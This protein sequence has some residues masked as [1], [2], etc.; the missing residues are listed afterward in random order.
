MANFISDIP[1]SPTPNGSRQL[2]FLVEDDDNPFL[3]GFVEHSQ[4][5]MRPP[6]PRVEVPAML[7]RAF[8]AGSINPNGRII[9]PR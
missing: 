1:S 6:Q 8:D 4:L 9:I 3:R 2:P 7:P 5:R